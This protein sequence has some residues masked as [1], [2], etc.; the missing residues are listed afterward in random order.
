MGETRSKGGTVSSFIERLTREVFARHSNPWSAWTRLLS[1]PLVF[2]AIWNRS[3]RGG[4]LLGAWM[5][6]NPIVFPE[7]EDDE[8][9][10]TRAVLGEEMWLAERP[11]DRAMAL[12]VGAT[13]LSLVGVW[14]AFGRRLLPTAASAVGQVALLLVLWRE[15]ALYY[16]RHRDERG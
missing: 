15:Y 13:A 11:I 1:A 4:A 12:N 2:V 3:P 9:W 14:G 5:L 16:E 8:A 10:A 6:A 7:P